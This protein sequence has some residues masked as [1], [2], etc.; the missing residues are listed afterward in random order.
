M[1]KVSKTAPSLPKIERW[2]E[3]HKQEVIDFFQAMLAIPAISPLSGGQGEKKKADFLEQYLKALNFG[4]IERYDAPDPTAEGGIRPN[5]IFYV[6]QKKTIPTLWFICHLDI[7]PVG[8]RGA[9][10]FDPY[11]PF[12]KDGKLFGRGAEDNGQSLVATLFAIKCLHNLGLK[13]V[14]RVGIAFVADEETQSKFGIE[15]LLK[16]G[17]IFSE[18][19]LVV[20]PD[21]GFAEGN[22]IEIAEKTIL[23]MKIEVTGQ[24]THGSTPELGLNA[25]RIGMQFAIE[26]DKQLHRKYPLENPLF[27]PPTCTFEPTKKETNQENINAVPGKD[28]LYF[29]CRILPEYPIKDVLGEIERMRAI[30]EKATGSKIA[31][32][33][34]SNLNLQ[35]PPTPANSPVVE[36]LNAAIKN[37]RGI[38]PILGGVGGGTCGAYFRIKG[39]PVAVYERTD[40]QAHKPN[41]YCVLDWLFEELK[42]FTLMMQA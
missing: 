5:I 32:S 1:E 41:E 29:D 38:D 17:G 35:A 15:F 24:Q 26:L 3:D 22:F 37:V 14:K 25:H 8:D 18:T 34:L 23:W 9:W 33:F 4:T 7:V 16:R 28:V 12:V 40:G 39:I 2:I 27:K 11:K 21:A 19:D 10:T 30:F 31:I 13:P 42:I 36:L 20:V 6:G